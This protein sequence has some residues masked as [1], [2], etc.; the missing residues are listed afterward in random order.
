MSWIKLTLIAVLLVSSV[1]PAAGGVA[2]DIDTVHHQP[3]E[4]LQERELNGSF[5]INFTVSFDEQSRVATVT[6]H[7]GLDRTQESVFVINVDDRPFSSTRHNLSSGES[8]SWRINVTDGLNAVEKNHTVT[9]STRGDYV[10]YNFTEEFDPDETEVLP[11]P[12]ITDVTVENGT[13]RGEP[14][15]V[16]MVTLRNPSVQTYGMKLMAFTEGTDGSLYPSSVSPKSNR[17]IKVE[18]L[19]PRGK[20]VA[21]EVRLYSGNL[22][23]GDGGID[24]VEFVGRAGEETNHWNQSY[25]AVK[26][27]WRK[28]NYVYQNESVPDSDVDP[29]VEGIDDRL[30]GAGVAA[31][32]L[33]L[34]AV[35]LVARRR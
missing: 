21:G 16:A 23:A 31:A 33:A 17:T 35:L 15:T 9:I 4:L 24:Q 18:L 6:A 13:I 34:L 27:T 12:R 1:Q 25:E 32:V 20:L 30:V 29:L 3:N 2:P 11:V 26:G 7:N 28:D 14:S 8:K 19:D 5:G 22:S 10:Q